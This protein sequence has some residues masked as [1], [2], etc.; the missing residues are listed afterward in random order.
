MSPIGQKSQVFTQAWVSPHPARGNF[1][2]SW[3]RLREGQRGQRSPILKANESCFV[4]VTLVGT[5][6]RTNSNAGFENAGPLLR[7]HAHRPPG[8]S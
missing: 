1:L 7:A 6:A 8:K 4:S 2:V 3:V 5:A